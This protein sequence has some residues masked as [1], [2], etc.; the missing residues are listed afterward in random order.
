[1]SRRICIV[2]SE[3]RRRCLEIFSNI[4]DSEPTVAEVE[5]KGS[6]GPPVLVEDDHL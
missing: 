2:V 4:P 1:M 5:A 3:A 6:E